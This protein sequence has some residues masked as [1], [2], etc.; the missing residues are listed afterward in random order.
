[1][2][3]DRDPQPGDKR[4]HGVRIPRQQQARQWQGSPK[5]QQERLNQVLSMA[6]K[7]SQDGEQEEEGMSELQEAY[8]VGPRGSACEHG[9]LSGLPGT[10]SSRRAG[11]QI[12]SRQ[13]SVSQLRPEGVWE[14]RETMIKWTSF[15]A[16]A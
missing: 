4:T 9:R 2:S 7:Q 1:M 15:S 10:V 11:V 16:P 8:R 12:H 6:E 5:R 13:L 3:Q 14:S